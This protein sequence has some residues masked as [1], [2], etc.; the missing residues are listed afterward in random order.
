FTSESKEAIADYDEIR[1]EMKLALQE[2]GRKLGIYLR[3]R[4]RMRREAERRS[5]FERYIGEIA[6]SCEAITGTDGDKIYK[7]LL[8]QAKRKTEEADFELD[9]DG[10]VIDDGG[11]LSDDQSVM[12]VEEN[13]AYIN[14]NGG[15]PNS[16]DDDET[17]F[18]S[19]GSA[20]TKTK[21]K[22]TTKRKRNGR[23]K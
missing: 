12:I 21:K 15:E 8:I 6:K 10:N 1:K 14:G 16:L 13:Q 19:D 3:R 5:T 9:E 20:K 2:C 23:R 22:R 11:R 17:L 4:K 7:A 18:G